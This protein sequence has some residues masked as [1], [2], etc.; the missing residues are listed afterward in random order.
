MITLE[1][2]AALSNRMYEPSY[3][4]GLSRS[5]CLTRYRRKVVITSESVFTWVSENQ[6]LPSVSRAEIKDILGATCLSEKVPAESDGTHM[7]R[8]KRV[9]LSQLWSTLII[10]RPASSSGNIFNAY[11]YRSTKHL[12]R[13]P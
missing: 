10:R 1:C 9:P 11:C 13:L 7:R 6:I 12:S 3:H 5:S 4:P 8:M 2:Q